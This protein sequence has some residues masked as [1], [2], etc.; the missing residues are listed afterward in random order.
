MKTSAGKNLMTPQEY[1]SELQQPQTPRS[2]FDRGSEIM[3]TL[4]AGFL[5]PI[6]WD[7]V[8]PSDTWNVSQS[9][10]AR[11][12]TLIKPLMDN[13]YLDI[14]WFFVPNRLL[15]N[16]WVNLMGEQ[17]DPENPVTYTTPQVEIK[18][19]KPTGTVVGTHQVGDYLGLPTGVNNLTVSAYPFR[20]Y[21]KIYDDYYRDENLIKKQLPKI[22]LEQLTI[23]RI[24]CVIFKSTP[25]PSQLS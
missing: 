24:G 25:Q 6:F 13:L 8:L 21:K 23:I 7:E 16:K 4:D 11:I 5:V 3:T 12:T 15:D 9:L 17:D 18:T 14:H 10:F 19:S 22:P 1:F 20:C 2:S